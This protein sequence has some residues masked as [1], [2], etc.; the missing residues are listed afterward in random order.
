MQLLFR[1]RTEEGRTDEDR[2]RRSDGQLSRDPAQLRLAE[3]AMEKEGHERSRPQQNAQSGVTRTESAQVG[4]GAHQ[5]RHDQENRRPV[6]GHREEGG[7]RRQYG[8]G[9]ERV[10]RYLRPQ[11]PVLPAH[12]GHAQPHDR[13]EDQGNQQ[14]AVMLGTDGRRNRGRLRRG[15]RPGLQRT[16]QPDEKSLQEQGEADFHHGLG[17][18]RQPQEAGVR[19][20]EPVPRRREAIPAGARHGLNPS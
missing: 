12:Q 11:G 6:T 5:H 1:M 4:A 19:T 7:Q 20:C 13:P 2:H 18:R 15:G 10:G 17:G 14:H 9:H 16:G 8:H 3:L